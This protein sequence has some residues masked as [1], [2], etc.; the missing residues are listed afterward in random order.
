MDVKFPNVSVDLLEPDGNIFNLVGI[1]TKAMRKAGI[2][3]EEIAV[4]Q[5]DVMTSG[6]YDG[7]LQVIMKTVNVE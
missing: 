5:K 6:S 7:A 4:F 3:K 2:S 1:C